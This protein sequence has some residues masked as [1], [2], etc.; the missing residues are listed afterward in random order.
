[1]SQSCHLFR[2]GNQCF[3]TTENNGP[4]SYACLWIINEISCYFFPLWG[5]V[6][7]TQA[8]DWSS[9]I[10]LMPG[11]KTF[12]FCCDLRRTTVPLLHHSFN[13]Q[14]VRLKLNGWLEISGDDNET[15]CMHILS[16]SLQTGI[17]VKFAQHLKHVYRRGT[18]TDSMLMVCVRQHSQRI[19]WVETCVYVCESNGGWRGVQ[20]LEDKVRE[21]H[22]A[23]RAHSE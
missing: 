4:Q 8:V 21:T 17:W 9:F 13:R 7:S 12:S 2:I 20:Y 19:F 5:F 15:A 16:V 3:A 6:C 14:L 1:M 10:I 23:G 22:T 11:C 18:G